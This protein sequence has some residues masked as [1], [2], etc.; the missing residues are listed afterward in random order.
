MKLFD[1]V[2]YV[3]PIFRLSILTIGNGLL[4][5]DK[6]KLILHHL[7]VLGINSDERNEIR[8]ASL[9]LGMAF[10]A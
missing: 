9:L 10:V 1:Q 8:L 7:H 5:N 4:K 3:I 6:I 2:N